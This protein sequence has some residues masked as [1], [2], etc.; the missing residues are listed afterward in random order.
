M[1]QRVT[2]DLGLFSLSHMTA[3]ADSLITHFT[4]FL[5][6]FSLLWYDTLLFFPLLFSFDSYS[7]LLF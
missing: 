3:L 1:L 5:P 6:R 4:P 7:L 2:K